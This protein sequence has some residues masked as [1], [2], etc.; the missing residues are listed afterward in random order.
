MATTG[1]TN[2]TCCRWRVRHTNIVLPPTIIVDSNLV[3]AKHF[4]AFHTPHPWIEQAADRF[5]DIL[6]LNDSIGLITLIGLNELL[7]F[8]IRARYQSALL[9]LREALAKARPRQR[10]FGWIDLYKARPDILQ[11]ITDELEDL[12]RLLMLK[13]L[14]Y[15]QPRDVLPL[16][17]NQLLEYALLDHIRRYQLDTNDA[18]MLLEAR[19]AGIMSIATLDSDIRRAAV[20]FDVYT[21]TA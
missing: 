6:E 12:Q 1:E 3:I 16:P 17:D 18:A 20:D 8:A 14:V 10:R 21:W 7:H 5:F 2:R 19:R 15:V 4:T 9:E 11:T 13:G